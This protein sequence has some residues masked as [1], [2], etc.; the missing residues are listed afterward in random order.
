MN[1]VTAMAEAEFWAAE[2][3]KEPKDLKYYPPT[4]DDP[5]TW[6]G[7]LRY[8]WIETMAAYTVGLASSMVLA[9]TYY[10]AAHEEPADGAKPRVCPNCYWEAD[11]YDYA[12]KLVKR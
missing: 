12:R 1:H 6:K 4:D 5:E 7:A 3:V 8:A 2:L 9:E 11:G 10:C